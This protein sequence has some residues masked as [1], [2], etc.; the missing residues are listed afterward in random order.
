MCIDIVFFFHVVFRGIFCS[1]QLNCLSDLCKKSLYDINV[2]FAR[3]SE[4]R[5]IYMYMHQLVVI[6][7]IYIWLTGL[8]TLDPLHTFT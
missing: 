4:I 6:M 5:C 8:G 1:W 2:P 7:R 3:A